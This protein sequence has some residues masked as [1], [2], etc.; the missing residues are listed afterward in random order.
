MKTKM[1]KCTRCKQE[2]VIREFYRDNR[3]HCASCERESARERMRKYNATFRGRSAQALNDS[4]KTARKYGVYDDLTLDDIMYVF[5][6]S[7]GECVYCGK[8]SEDYQLEHIVPMSRGGTNTLSNITTSCP[9]C[10]IAKHNNSL[11]MWYIHDG[12]NKT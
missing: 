4:R 2:K 11:F 1:K 5:S 12:R 9:A 7:G 8:V 3:S 6:I 10:N